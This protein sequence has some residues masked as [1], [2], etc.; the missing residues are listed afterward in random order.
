VQSS[1]GTTYGIVPSVNKHAVGAVAGIVGAGGNAGALIFSTIFK[2]SDNWPDVFM[3]VGVIVSVSAFLTF[4][5]DVDGARITPGCSRD[6]NLDENTKNP[7]SPGSL[8]AHS[9]AT[10]TT[11]AQTGAGPE[12]FELGTK[13]KIVSA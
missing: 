2:Y 5:L 12:A 6:T 7:S 9:G 11:K 1:E 3:I 4:F 13:P 10:P 8:T